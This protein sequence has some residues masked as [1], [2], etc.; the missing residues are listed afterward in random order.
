MTQ[1]ILVD[2]LPLIVT[3]DDYSEVQILYYVFHRAF[4]EVPFAVE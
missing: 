4:E 2:L 1:L 3:L